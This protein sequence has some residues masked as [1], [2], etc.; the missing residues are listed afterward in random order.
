MSQTLEIPDGVFDAL[1][2]AAE[3]GGITPVG[4]IEARLAEGRTQAIGMQAAAPARTLADR[5]A[6]RYGFVDSGGS[7]RLSE[8]EGDDF[9]AHLEEK[10]RQGCL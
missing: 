7:E 1:K 3:A 2:K 6:G 9:A 5:F 4:W 10:R 8:R